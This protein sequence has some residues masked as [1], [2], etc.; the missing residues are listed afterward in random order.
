MPP[1][2]SLRLAAASGPE[3]DRFAALL[4]LAEMY[5]AYSVDSA[6]T[7]ARQGYD[8]A[9]LIG[10]PRAKAMASDVLGKTYFGKGLY[11]LARKTF[12]DGLQS[13]FQ[14]NDSLLVAHLANSN[15]VALTRDGN[16]EAALSNLLT[17]ARIFEPQGDPYQ[18]AAMKINIGSLQMSLRRYDAAIQTFEQALA[19]SRRLQNDMIRIP[20]LNNL[21]SIYSTLDQQERALLS[22]REALPPEGEPLTDLHIPT[23]LNLYSFYTQRGQIP[24]GER[25]YNQ[26][27]TLAESSGNNGWRQQ[28]LQRR[29]DMLFELRQY[30]R[31]SEAYF[32]SLNFCRMLNQPPIEMELQQKLADTYARI[33]D[34]R[35]AYDRL[36]AYQRIN[37]ELYTEA[38]SLHIAEMETRYE[39]EEKEREIAR[40]QEEE[41]IQ[42]IK[43]YGALLVAAFFI[44]ALVALYSR[45][46]L[47]QRAHAL[48]ATQHAEIQHKNELLETQSHAIQAQNAELMQVNEDLKLFARA[49]SHDLRE[50]L[51]TI[52]K[53]LQLFLRNN[54][55]ESLASTDSLAF[56]IDGAAR[57]D[58][59]VLR[60]LDY[61][62]A[63]RRQGDRQLVRLNAVVDGVLRDLWRQL[64]DTQAEV[65]IG[66]LPEIYGYEVDLRLMFQNLIQNALK[67][68]PPGR[69]PHI[70]IASRA[71][72]GGF[73][74]SVADNGIGIDPQS[75]SK[76]FEPF[77]RSASPDSHEGVGLG[78]AICKRVAEIHG[79]SIWAEP[80]PGGGSIFWI[81]L[82]ATPEVAG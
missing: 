51:R 34:Y 44:T 66:Q 39:L 69:K 25:A 50:P 53:H 45:F 72:E 57:M 65:E 67:F 68:C 49:A 22:F 7:Y 58:H 15:A 4:Q 56:A 54:A 13:A 35:Q 75:A 43:V 28:L 11:I 61:A 38:S 14:S 46:V 18:M 80:A 9:L 73:L 29:G 23:L 55:T 19:L 52:R 32:A 70:A 10:T 8:L 63:G 12:A 5:H 21:G 37:T 71:V 33:G 76:I 74:L 79:G 78:L 20:V 27:Y 17:A 40:L 31:A 30:V 47:K 24:E 64:Q 6:M 77:H 81:R 42:Q 16:Y 36:Q 41:R 3:E 82:P 48:L 1:L 62:R 59:I 2:D 26:A 60:L